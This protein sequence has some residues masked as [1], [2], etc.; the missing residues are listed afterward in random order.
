MSNGLHVPVMMLPRFDELV[1]AINH[2]LIE[3]KMSVKDV[4]VGIGVGKGV[5]LNDK[6]VL[7]QNLE[8]DNLCWVSF[9][10]LEETIREESEQDLPVMAHVFS[11]LKKNSSFAI[12]VAYAIASGLGGRIIYDD[13]H[14]YLGGVDSLSLGSVKELYLSKDIR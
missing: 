12:A 7:V 8:K 10:F 2:P 4:V 14:L 9:F 6:F 13:A 3:L 5:N 1:E 11:R